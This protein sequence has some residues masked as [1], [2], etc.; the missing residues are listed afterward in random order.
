MYNIIIFTAGTIMCACAHNIYYYI[1]VISVMV[2]NI[3]VRA[4]RL[5]LGL[6]LRSHS[7]RKTGC[8]IIINNANNM[9]VSSKTLRSRVQ[10][11]LRY[12]RG[13]FRKDKKSPAGYDI[14]IC[15]TI[16]IDSMSIR[17][18]VV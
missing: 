15:N 14:C 10:P 11:A 17:L 6:R 1:I 5:G 9:R 3:G 7:H 16:V 2:L 8:T 13:I 4:E 18:Y 12:A